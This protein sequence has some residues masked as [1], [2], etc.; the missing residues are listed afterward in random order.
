MELRHL[1]YFVAVAE[2]LHFGRAARR[3]G[4]TQPPLSQQIQ[5]LEA[6]IGV[7]LFRRSR[8]HVDLTAAGHAFLREARAILAHA[9]RAAETARRVARG[10]AGQIR[11]GFV[12]SATYD[13]FVP[14]ILRSFRE[15]HPGVELVLTEMT[16]AQQVDELRRRTLDVGFVR[17]PAGGGAIVAEPIRRERLYAALPSNH[18]LAALPVI[19][20]SD[21]SDS[22][23]VML[24]QRLSLGLNDQI[25]S[26]CRE[27]G[28]EPLVVQ[29]AAEMHTIVSLVAAGIGVSVVPD[30]AR[31]LRAKTVAYVPFGNP[32]A[33]TEM[34]VTYRRD[35]DSPVVHAFIDI[36]HRQR[37]QGE[38]LAE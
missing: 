26:L 18:R 7:D 22:P 15:S 24:P 20:L 17:P 5:A 25:V 32:E 1:R 36:V 8:R 10:V 38:S 2:D 27:A 33:S 9:E 19:A 12:G 14:S 31:N 30:S 29:E 16:T 34:A 37:D 6:E 3:L 4:M 11:V 35:D 13:D 23:F 28:F 21:L